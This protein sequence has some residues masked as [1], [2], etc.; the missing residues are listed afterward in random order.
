VVWFYLGK[1]F[2]P[3]NLVFVYP[4]W[5]IDASRWQAHVP[6][7]LLLMVLALAF[8][9]RKGWGRPVLFALGY[10][11]VMLTPVLGFFDIYFMLYSFVA[12]HYQYFALIGPLALFAGVGATWLARTAGVLQET[13][14]GVAI[15]LP[16]LLGFLSWQQSHIYHDNFTLWRDTLKKNPDA[17]L[18]H[19]N[20]GILLRDQREL[21]EAAQ[22]FQEVLRI[23]PDDAWAHHELGSIRQSQGRFDEAAFHY[24]QAI[25][26]DPTLAQ[27]RYNLGNL[28]LQLGNP[29]E[30]VRSYQEALEIR[31]DFADA[32]SN[33]GTAY[34]IQ[35]RTSEA[36]AHYREALRL[37]PSNAQAHYNLG[38]NLLKQGHREEAEMHLEQF[39]RLNRPRRD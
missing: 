35:G 15:L 22:H 28:A 7:L 24:R 33:L 29:E 23:R 25:A 13:L 20:L 2:W 5:D 32:H 8:S 38:Q 26:N 18:A 12:D 31:P 16:F 6:N 17:W 36:I 37:D 27:T 21:D 10:F 39:R 34:Q 1:A 4:R 11:L 19:H 3:V 30:A 14:R 9:F